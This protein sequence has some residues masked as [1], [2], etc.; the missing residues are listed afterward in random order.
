VV[1]VDV[2]GLRWLIVQIRVKEK[3]EEAEIKMKMR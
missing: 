3:F 2:D 1:E